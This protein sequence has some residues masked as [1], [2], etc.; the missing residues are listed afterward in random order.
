MQKLLPALSQGTDGDL[1]MGGRLR[2][3]ALR[4]ATL[5]VLTAVVVMAALAAPAEEAE[6][7]TLWT[8]TLN[9]KSF[10]EYS[11]G[12]SGSSDDKSCAAAMTDNTFV[13]DGET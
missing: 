9:I 7:A 8:S 4:A 5:L 11:R 13:I 1:D 3:A 2:R 12:C 10:G 6:A